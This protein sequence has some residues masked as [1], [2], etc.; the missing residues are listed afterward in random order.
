MGNTMCGCKTN[1]KKHKITSEP[2]NLHEVS[3]QNDENIQEKI[4]YVPVTREDFFHHTYLIN[5]VEEFAYSVVPEKL[6]S[7]QEIDRIMSLIL[8]KKPE[9]NLL[10]RSSSW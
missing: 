2:K 9:R 6:R 7:L 1:T 10:E 8:Y 5:E 4:V 3:K